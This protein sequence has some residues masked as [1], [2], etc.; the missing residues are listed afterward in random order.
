M[1]LES[2]VEN[3]GVQLQNHHCSESCSVLEELSYKLGYHRMRLACVIEDF[4]QIEWVYPRKLLESTVGAGWDKFDRTLGCLLYA[5]GSMPLEKVSEVVGACRTAREFCSIVK[6]C[7]RIPPTLMFQV[8]SAT[9]AQLHQAVCL[10]YWMTM[11]VLSPGVLRQKSEGSGY[12]VSDTKTETPVGTRLLSVGPGPLMPSWR[13][14]VEGQRG[15]WDIRMSDPVEASRHSP[16]QYSILRAATRNRGR[17]GR[18][19]KWAQELASIGTIDPRVEIRSQTHQGLDLVLTVFPPTS[20]RKWIN[21]ENNLCVLWT[22]RAVH[23]GKN[24][25][26]QDINQ[27]AMEMAGLL[28][29]CKNDFVQK[30]LP[31]VQPNTSL[32]ISGHWVYALLCPFWGKVYVGAAGF[33]KSRTPLDRWTEHVHLSKLWKESK[34]TVRYNPRAPSMYV[35]YSKV[36][37]GNVVMVILERVPAGG[38][39]LAMRERHYIRLFSPVWNTVSVSESASRGLWKNVLTEEPLMIAARLL[40]QANPKLPEAQWVHLIREVMNLG[41]RELAM[42]LARVARRI[43]PSLVALR[44]SPRLTFPCP[45]PDDVQKEATGLISH[46]VKQ[47]PHFQR[48]VLFEQAVSVKV[49]WRGSPFAEQLIAPSRIQVERVGQCNCKEIRPPN[50]HGHV[51]VRDWQSVEQCAQLASLFRDDSLQQRLYP[52]VTSIWRGIESQLHRIMCSAGFAKKPGP[53]GVDFAVNYVRERLLPQ[54]QQWRNKLPNHLRKEVVFKAVESVWRSGFVF[55]KLDR[56]PGRVVLMCVEAWRSLHNTTFKHS[57]YQTVTDSAGE[58]AE[59]AKDLI[60]RFQKKM[61]QTTGKKI[62]SILPPPGA[63][64]PVGSWTVKNKSSL[65]QPGEALLKVRPLVA[66]H[67]HPLKNVLKRIGRALSLL[68]E[69]AIPLVMEVRPQHTPIWRLHSGLQRWMQLLSASDGS[70]VIKRYLSIEEFDVEDCFLNCPQGEVLTAITFWIEK[71]KKR[72]REAFFAISKDHKSGDHMG[73]TS[74]EHHWVISSEEVLAVVAWELE[75]GRQFRVQHPENTS[76][77]QN[78]QQVRGVPI[79]EQLS[80]AVVELVSLQ[81]EFAG[82]WPAGLQAV[83]TA[84]YRDNFFVVW[85][86]GRTRSGGAELAGELTTLLGMPVKWEGEAE[87]RRILELHVDVTNGVRCTLGFRTDADRQGEAKDTTCW[88]SRN[89]PRSRK[90]CGAILL[91]LASKIR[92]YHDSAAT[93]YTATWRKV[94]Q[95]VKEKKYPARWWRR[96]L[97]LAAVR[98]GARAINLPKCL[99]QALNPCQGTG[100]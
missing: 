8:L 74:S 48:N 15:E 23:G 68:V 51:V 41:E 90:L 69:A 45:I 46:I 64:I 2:L 53:L 78:L 88:P 71:T 9:G 36:G 70:T 33:E 27:T 25:K 56:N 67:K 61:V 29:E 57:R 84:R 40:R 94:V 13:I 26:L 80:A 47:L 75:H 59:W 82:P 35:A 73:W 12:F 72:R 17:N 54:L 87:Q 83:P 18:L 6:K 85:P 49:T 20:A 76:E 22:N 4:G 93:G 34:G 42:K 86:V 5:K 66:Y 52:T 97:A 58:E 96:R 3:F 16:I 77:F 43:C 1:V 28:V 11:A 62:P 10:T 60:D 38:Q 81:R 65:L 31:F 92:V 30:V 21:L 99:R 37:L 44:A 79:G 32:M 14:L 50:F 19:S 55:V 39:W 63:T 89:D 100:V 98:N 91:G 7:Q 24:Q 95:F